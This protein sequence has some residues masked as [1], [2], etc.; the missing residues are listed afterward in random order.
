MALSNRHD[1]ELRG[2]GF[3]LS[4]NVTDQLTLVAGGVLL[5]ARVRADA[6]A[7]GTIGRRPVGMPGHI[8]SVDANWDAASLGSRP[9]D[10]N[11][12]L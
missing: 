6:D 5:D 9:V 3:S 1:E 7:A 10:S 4:G 2:A 12:A 11:A 8:F